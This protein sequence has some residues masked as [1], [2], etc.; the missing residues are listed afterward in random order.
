M[1]NAFPRGGSLNI[2]PTKKGTKRKIKEDSIFSNSKRTNR[3]EVVNTI[4]KK[5]TETNDTILP[6]LG[7]AM[8]VEEDMD[9]NSKIEKLTGARIST[10]TIMIGYVMKVDE[11]SAL[12]SLPGGNKG[13]VEQN[14]VSDFAHGLPE[15]KQPAVGKFLKPMQFVR[16]IVLAPQEKL[17]KNGF[18]KILLSLRASLLN[19]GVLFKHLSKGFPVYGCVE[20]KEDHGYVI[21]AG[22]RSV[23]CFLPTKAIPASMG[24]L[25]IGQPVECIVNEL[26][27][28]AKLVFLRAHPKAVRDSLVLNAS[29]P[30]QAVTAG[31]LVHATVKKIV[32]NGF[33]VNFLGLFQGVI[34]ENSLLNP[35]SSDV[36]LTDATGIAVGDILPARIVFVDPSKSTPVRLSLRPHVMEMRGPQFLPPLG[37]ILEDLQVTSINGKQ[38]IFM[39]SK[40][41]L[42]ESDDVA[43]DDDEKE[44]NEKID[45]KEKKKKM[46]AK[47]QQ[48][49]ETAEKKITICIPRSSLALT[50]EQT[51]DTENAT[52][53]ESEGEK[54][55]TP[56]DETGRSLPIPADKLRKTY[57]VGMKVPKVRV[58]GY[59]LV[60]GLV[61]ASNLSKFIEED[62][63]HASS[64]E[65][66]AVFKAKVKKIVE[67][68]LVVGLGD[69]KVTA[70]CPLVH[71][72]DTVLSA[73]KLK[74]RFKLG[75]MM[76]VRVWSKDKE[77]IRVTNKRNLVEAK[78]DLLLMDY[79]DAKPGKTV[80]GITTK[81]SGKEGI[82]MRFFN[83]VRGVIPPA[84]LSK[85]GV[86]DPSESYRVGQVLQVVVIRRENTEITPLWKKIA[87]EQ[88]D[89]PLKKVMVPSICLALDL[90]LVKSE[91]LTQ[92]ED[93]T[94][95][96][97]K[98]RLESISNSPE[99]VS[100]KVFKVEKEEILEKNPRVQGRQRQIYVATIRL[101]DGR[102]AKMQQYHFYDFASTAETVFNSPVCPIKEGFRVEK[103]LVLWE[104]SNILY[105]TMKP[106][107]LHAA[108]TTASTQLSST[109]TTSTQLSSTEQITVPS[110]VA[111]LT[112]GQVVAGY[113]VSVENFVLVRFRR[114]LKA[115]APR[116]NIA[117][118][119]VS[120]P[121]G[122]FVVGDAIRCVIQRVDLTTERVVVTFK[123]SIV[124]PSHFSF[125]SFEH[126]SSFSY[127]SS[128]FQEQYIKAMIESETN[129]RILPKWGTACPLNTVVQA[130][131]TSIEEYGVLLLADDQVSML[132]ARSPSPQAL[133]GLEEGKI[134]SVRVFDIDYKHSVMECSLEASALKAPEKV[135]KLSLTVGMAV[136]AKVLSVK[137]K[138]LVVETGFKEKGSKTTKSNKTKNETVSIIGFLMLAD[139]HKPKPDPVAD[140]FTVGQELSVKVLAIPE[141]L[142]DKKRGNP[143]VGQLLVELA[144]EETSKVMK[145]RVVNVQKEAEESDLQLHRELLGITDKVED[146]T[147]VALRQKFL[148][149][150]RVGRVTRWV[151]ESYTHTEMV[152]VPPKQDVLKLQIKAILHISG[153]INPFTSEDQLKKMLKLHSKQGDE[154]KL[155]SLHPFSQFNKGDSVSCYVLQVRHQKDTGKE[156]SSSS[157]RLT[158]FL[159]LRLPIDEKKNP[160]NMEGED[161][162][163]YP[164]YEMR[165]VQGTNQVKCPSLIAAVVIKKDS[166]GCT[167]ALSPYL[168]THLP[169]SAISKDEKIMELFKKSCFVGLRLVVAVTHVGKEEGKIKTIQLSR[170]VAEEILTDSPSFDITKS[171]VDLSDHIVEG[172]FSHSVEEGQLL[173]GTLDLGTKKLGQPLAVGVLLKDSGLVGR[174][175]VTELWD[176]EQW[177][178]LSEFVRKQH[179]RT[180]LPDGRR[181]GDEVQCR[182][183]SVDK[184]H[185]ELSLRPSRVEAKKI[186]AALK[187][188][189]LPE[190]GAVVKGFV[191]KTAQNLGSFIRLT[192]NHTGHVMLREL[193]DEFVQAP[194]KAYPSGK[195]VEARILR[196]NFETGD[197]P[198]LTLR[199]SAIH[200]N[201]QL[202]EEI[203]KLSVGDTVVATVTKVT[204]VGVFVSLEGT[205]I[206]ALSRPFAASDLPQTALHEEFSVGDVVRAKVLRV[207]K[208]SSKVEVGL[209]AK[210]FKKEEEEGEGD[211]EGEI[212][213]VSE[214]EEGSEEEN[215]G[216]TDGQG[217]EVDEE[218]QENSDIENDDDD[219]DSNKAE[220]EEDAGEA[221]A[222]VDDNDDIDEIVESGDNDD[223]DNIE[224]D[225]DADDV[226]EDDDDDDDD[227]MKQNLFQ[228]GPFIKSKSEKT[229]GKSKSNDLGPLQWE[230]GFIG[231]VDNNGMVVTSMNELNSLEEDEEEQE[232]T[233]GKGQKM[234][235]KQ[236]DAARRKEELA[237]REREAALAEGT[238]VP[239][240]PEDFERMVIAEPNSS[241][242]WLQYMAHFLQQGA[243]VEA[244]RAVAYRALRTIDYRE[245]DEKYNMWIGLLNM[246]HKYGSMDSLAA[247]FSRASTESKGKQIHIA[248]AST[249]E[250]AGDFSGAEEMFRKALKRP[251]YKKSKKVWVAFLKMKLRSG[252]VTGA[253]EQLS[254]AMQSLSKHK[255]VEVISKY[256]L[257]EFELGS[258]DRGRVVFEE[259]IHNYGKRTDIWHLYLDK[260][261]KL[262][263]L[264]Q[265]RQLF[266]RMITLKTSVKNMKTIFKKYLAFEEKYGDEQ[267]QE[268]VKQKAQEYV[269]SIA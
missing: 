62:V 69:S 154:D 102:L 3:I 155:S 139:Y 63:V 120:T 163:F 127:T 27:E 9:E 44:E 266:D 50:P 85:Q 207:R 68:G 193:S 172:D 238:L 224:D 109:S 252:D 218:D 48:K 146:T 215:E 132:L 96:G 39:L 231:K 263:N 232:E 4:K 138:Y 187:P 24:D 197:R 181:H 234:R 105:L 58:S 236:K 176:P 141:T 123:P 243:D 97:D 45:K 83:N 57:Q 25:S 98:K 239:E 267:K 173:T 258:V 142:D 212:E 51:I 87:Q 174:V 72:T 133:E 7:I 131:V 125:S 196:R 41:S 262:G 61:T 191:V 246:E 221:M 115:L 259:L 165:Q 186:S 89:L 149:K 110:R 16:C 264:E 33:L 166:S 229:S 147:L 198:I 36:S 64:I 81:V 42:Q 179:Q 148:S 65:V 70:F 171:P 167:V 52:T 99:F 248:M 111:D 268:I 180:P 32:Q 40:E 38:S 160:A 161:S 216:I 91:L 13:V 223:D 11:T 37:E 143:H 20:S 233:S 157:E 30:F 116:P 113:V 189:Q 114:N 247:A 249:Y 54:E 46:A 12:I 175:C 5:K 228:S 260:E 220:E 108:S 18:S 144:S 244:A 251:Q 254:R 47:Q 112:P 73:A 10:G 71:V 104:Q 121:Q 230:N 253:K 201:Q 14:E 208:T 80:I 194:A 2:K 256:A 75:Q 137:D 84:A 195:L 265:A 219:D 74:E 178:D 17:G 222:V 145:K 56:L 49:R 245:E 240:T 169:F 119:F 242:L 1:S 28:D 60:E 29:L 204:P 95:D 134:V 159:S 21:Q 26:K 86:L 130:T 94:I 188:D 79:N 90:N 31:M 93:V 200:G 210:Y 206:E 100:G 77:E 203:E 250:Q 226:D 225:S 88:T 78:D 101:D 213:G 8:D 185:I 103:A 35:F 92:M 107:L 67:K 117:D 34:D 53:D 76:K 15:N 209:R 261:V 168:S 237:I 22:I 43:T 241:F 126:T 153:A 199:H 82:A 170:T 257:A 106:L 59:N 190:E 122:L 202:K 152:L 192:V 235:S 217:M 227:E 214:G 211:M 140:G 151:V 19:K 6:G 55:S 162:D 23:N 136:N 182:V 184:G 205:S 135:E 255:H 150:L 66:G 118:K 177:Q 158:V 128:F 183:L 164:F 269:N 156:G 124:T 129:D